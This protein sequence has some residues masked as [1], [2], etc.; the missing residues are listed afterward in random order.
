[1][2]NVVDP[3]RRSTSYEHR[4]GKYFQRGFKIVLSNLNVNKLRTEI[5]G[6][7]YFEGLAYCSLSFK[8]NAGEGNRIL[9]DCVSR[10]F[11]HQLA[12]DYNQH[13]DNPFE[14]EDISNTY[15]NLGF[16]LIDVATL[17]GNV[18]SLIT[19]RN[20]FSSTKL[21]VEDEEVDLREIPFYWGEAP[22]FS[23][24]RGYG[25][26]EFYN[27]VK[28]VSS[29][30]ELIKSSLYKFFNVIP[31]SEVIE[32]LS[33]SAFF[34]QKLLFLEKLKERQIQEVSKF[35]NHN[36]VESKTLTF[37]TENPGT[38]LTSSVNPIIE[39]P[40]AYYGDYY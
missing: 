2:I 17:A 40:I 7:N 18:Q 10:S 1:M 27:D 5:I 29:R 36:I 3:S 21:P 33:S 34:E 16:T 28:L 30:K 12:S 26:T 22:K 14:L 31:I 23:D 11:R 9:V 4:L 38:Q 13:F 37:I 35:V 24:S 19:G 20:M 6:V 8:E 39:D 32:F 25:I 15:Q